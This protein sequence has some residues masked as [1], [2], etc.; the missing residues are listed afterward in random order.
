MIHVT[1]GKAP[2]V[3]TKEKGPARRE[4]AKAEAYYATV[5]P[6]TVTFPFKFYKASKDAYKSELIKQFGGRCAYCECQILVGNRG[7]IEHFRPKSQFTTRDGKVVR[8]GYYWL[9]ADWDNLYL[10]CVNCN[11]NTTFNILD[12]DNP[13]VIIQRTAG[14]M[15]QFA[16]LDEA[17]RR[18]EACDIESEEPYRLLIDPC[19]DRPETLLQFDETGVVRPKA[20]GGIDK[21]KAEYSICVYVLQRDILVKARREKYLLVM[22]KIRVVD[23][24]FKYV[25]KGMREETSDPRQEDDKKDLEIAFMKLLDFLNVETELNDYI[26]VAR[27]YIEPFLSRYA[28]SLADLLGAGSSGEA[29][30]AGAVDYFKPQVSALR[31]YLTR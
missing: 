23:K 26:G 31:A 13:G 24:T 17:Y 4:R 2:V 10:S 1:R 21:E 11:Q 15:D 20:A 14:K 29:W 27:Q 25:A 7:D 18:I 30:Y 8:P 3:F 9:A 12:A 6:P 5:P 28:A 22:D 19:K 16:L